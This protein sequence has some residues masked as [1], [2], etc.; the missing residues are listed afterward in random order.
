MKHYC[1]LPWVNLYA[2]L[3]GFEPCC[4]W[5]RLP[6]DVIPTDTQEGFLGIKIQKVR[7]DMLDGKQIAN[8][9]YCYTDESIGLK[10]FRQSAIDNWGI[11][12]DPKLQCLDIVFDNVCNLKCR[13]CNSSASHLW[14]SEETELYGRPLSETKYTKSSTFQS[15]DTSH[16]KSVTISGGEPFFSKDCEQFLVNLRNDKVIKDIKLT[17]ATNCTIVPNNETHQSLLECSDLNIVLSIDGVGPLNEYFRSP[18]DWNKCVEVMKYF[19]QL[20]DL[21]TDKQTSISV[22]TT[23]YIYNVN[24]LKEIEIFFQQNFPRFGRSKRN[25]SVEP[26]MLSIKNMPQDLKDL[27]RPIVE[28]YGSDYAEVLNMLNQPGE[29]L[30]DEFLFFHNKLDFLRNE[31]L[32]ET[33]QLLS[34]YID[35]HICTYKGYLDGR[36]VFS[37]I[38]SEIIKIG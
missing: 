34:N 28:S 26:T 21:R 38:T 17:F 29:D 2:E 30:F 19:D 37:C 22:R 20:I 23:V 1:P 10:S 8:C 27:V 9:E 11:V 35:Q 7:Q 31:K 3:D 25:I 16:L 4:N 24:K 36:K 13:G 15:I 32:G 12:T 33:N 6:N 5:K 14:Y 18:S